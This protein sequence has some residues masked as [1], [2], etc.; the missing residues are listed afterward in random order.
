MWEGKQYS[1]LEAATA[2]FT[3]IAP[4]LANIIE[5]SHG[6]VTQATAA[7]NE[8]FHMTNDF[9]I[10]CAVIDIAWFRPDMIHPG[11]HVPTGP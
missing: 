6:D 11:S 4:T 2:L 7:V 5:Q 1:R 9:P 10:F 3:A 8:R